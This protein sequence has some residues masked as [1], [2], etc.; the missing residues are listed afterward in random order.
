M[1]RRATRADLLCI[2][3]IRDAAGES[4]LSDSR[5]VTEAATDRLIDDGVLWV[6]QEAGGL[7]AGFCA[8]D[9]RDG[10]IWALL[11]A[12]G[13]EGKGIGRAL[14]QAA[15]D[16][17][18]AAGH[19]ATTIHIPAGSRAERHYRATGWTISGTSDKSELVFQKP[20]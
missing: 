12:P 14:L 2:L 4:P 10:S 15:C 13:Q 9:R 18:R 16:D 7:V 1:L 8:G 5:A 17:L 3:A 19:R 20:L 11:V 6:W